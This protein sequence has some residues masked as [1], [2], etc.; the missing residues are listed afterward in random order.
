MNRFMIPFL[1]IILFAALVYSQSD[2]DF[3]TYF[4]DHTMRIDYFH[5]GDSKQEFIT[6]DTIYRQGIWAG[7]PN[8]LIDN[9]NN[10]RYYIKIFDKASQKLIFSKGFDSYFGEYKT[11][12]QAGKGIKKTF[13]ETALIPYP[14]KEI[15]FTIEIRDR[16]NKLQP[17]FTRDI[18]PNSVEIIRESLIPNVKIFQIVKS[19]HPHQKVDLVF[20]AEGYSPK[21]ENKVKKDL[22]RVAQ[23]FFNQEPFQP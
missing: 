22:N 9:F 8:Q 18:N 15:L 14:K 3:N 17:F 21:E 6:I 10:G 4:S 13:H 5:T 23:I 19:G 7:N 16:E 12:S 20:V 11:T 1:M 2:P